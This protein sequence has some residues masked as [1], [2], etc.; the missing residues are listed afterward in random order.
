MM[1]WS[2]A[3]RFSQAKGPSSFPE[4]NVRIGL[5]TEILRPAFTQCQQ[6]LPLSINDR[7]HGC[8]CALSALCAKVVVWTCC[9]RKAR[10]RLGLVASPSTVHQQELAMMT[11]ALHLWGGRFFHRTTRKT[12]RAGFRHLDRPRHILSWETDHPQRG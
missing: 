3:V 12:D 8:L 4:G 1:C 5:P 2:E 11:T 10:R 9:E 7:T 6:L